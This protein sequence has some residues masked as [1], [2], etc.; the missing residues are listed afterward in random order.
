MGRPIKVEG[1]P[2]HPSS[3]GA[4]DA[5]AQ[6][7]ILDFYDPDRS[8]GIQRERPAERA[9]VAADGAARATAAAGRP[10]G[11]GF[12]I[13]TGPV[14]SPTLAA[15]IKA[16]IGQYPEAQWHVWE[17]FAPEAA[18]RGRELAYGR[19]VEVVRAWTRRT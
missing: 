2:E 15:S 7:L 4:T 1:N 18:R 9:A 16:L 3:L 12:R 11:R 6:A 13:L 14:C 10:A 8:T 5:L 17:P 19:Q